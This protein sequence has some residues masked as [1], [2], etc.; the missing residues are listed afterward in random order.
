M[1]RI[2]A[3]DDKEMKQTIPQKEL[4]DANKRNKDGIG[5]AYLNSRGFVEFEKGISLEKALAIYE[6]IESP[7]FIHFRLAS[8]GSVCP[9]LCHPFPLGG[10]LRLSGTVKEVIAHNGIWGGWERYLISYYMQ[11]K[12]E[13]PPAT[14]M[15]DTRLLAM[16]IKDCGRNVLDYLEVG[17]VAILDKD[18]IYLYGEWNES[19]GYYDSERAYKQYPYL[20]KEQHPYLTD[21]RGYPSWYL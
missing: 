5:L 1:C 11:K 3:W 21:P 15:S 17:R 20:F 16:I 12:I 13:V 7:G 8:S 10:D 6:R 14:L 4:L 19:G 18:G 2:F 9:E